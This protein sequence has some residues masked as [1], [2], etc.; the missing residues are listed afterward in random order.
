VENSEKECKSDAGVFRPSIDRNRCEGK[1]ACIVVCPYEVFTI[2][3]L[4]AQQ[5]KSLS[6]MGKLKSWAHK[7]RQA[8]VTNAD[9]C[10]GCGFCVAECPEKAISLKRA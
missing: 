1:A 2:G 3:T 6:L 5:R 8:F 4:T 9:A 7:W 10:H